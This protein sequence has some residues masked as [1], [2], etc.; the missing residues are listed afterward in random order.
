M[1]ETKRYD[2]S[3][4][5]RGNGR[6]YAE[7]TIM[8]LTEAEAARMGATKVSDLTTTADDVTKADAYERAL[9]RQDEM[10]AAET[11]AAETDSSASSKKRS[12]PKE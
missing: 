9:T 11:T 12:S 10:R 5:D 6:P 7:G 4:L 8:K 2:V 1:A 3:G